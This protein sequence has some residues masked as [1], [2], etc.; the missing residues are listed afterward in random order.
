MELAESG[1]KKSLHLFLA[2]LSPGRATVKDRPR[3]EAL[4]HDIGPPPSEFV[5]SEEA[6]RIEAVDVGSREDPCAPAA[7]WSNLWSL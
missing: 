5:E 2:A 1:P 6:K 4:G 7:A 3:R